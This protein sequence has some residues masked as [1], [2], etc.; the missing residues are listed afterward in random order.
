M[1]TSSRT[2]CASA[3]AWKGCR[4]SSTSW[5]ATSAGRPLAARSAGPRAGAKSTARPAPTTPRPDSFPREAGIQSPVADPAQTATI[6]ARRRAAAVIGL[7]GVA[8]IVALVAVLL[9]GG[10][11]NDG[12]GGDGPGGTASVIPADALAAVDLTIDRRDP[13]VTQALE[14]AQRLPDL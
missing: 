11:G 2:G 6:Y 9:T 3:T 13:A 8:A 4:R 7:L 5:S 14:V 12:G 1:P 10:G